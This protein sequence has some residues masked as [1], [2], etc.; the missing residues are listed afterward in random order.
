MLIANAVAAAANEP[1]A[2][3]KRVVAIMVP[4]AQEGIA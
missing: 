4:A 1:A 2:S 3:P